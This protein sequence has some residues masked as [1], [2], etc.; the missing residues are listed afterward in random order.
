MKSVKERESIRRY[1]DAAKQIP[2][3]LLSDSKRYHTI[4]GGSGGAMPLSS[5]H[6]QYKFYRRDH[7][8]GWFFAGEELKYSGSSAQ[9]SACL[10]VFSGGFIDWEK[11]SCAYGTSTS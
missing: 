10:G 9:A 8:S 5:Q 11:N 7:K 2:R 3:H 4:D 6:I 1:N